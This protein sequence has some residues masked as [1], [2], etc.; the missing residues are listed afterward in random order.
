MKTKQ[1]I[2]RKGSF[3]SMHR[4][5]NEKMKCFNIHGHT[6]LYELEFEFSQMEGIGYAIDFKEIKRIGCQ[7]IDDILDHGAIINPHDKDVY[8]AI[9]ATKSKF[10]DM[11]LNGEGNYCNPTVE[12]IA[13]EIFLAMQILFIDYRKTL[14]IN[15]ITLYETPNCYTICTAESISAKESDCFNEQ[16]GESLK[17]YATE[18]GTIEYD[19]RKEIKGVSAIQAIGNILDAFKMDKE[20]KNIGIKE[21]ITGREFKYKSNRFAKLMVLSRAGGKINLRINNKANESVWIQDLLND[22]N[23]NKIEFL[24]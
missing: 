12:N 8:R 20:D 3:D 24:N 17:K 2:T 7:W 23:E 14:R 19:D 21:F 15:K 16:N 1:T 5:M 9:E 11:S 13:K 10:W 6:Y 4:V 22:F 18:K